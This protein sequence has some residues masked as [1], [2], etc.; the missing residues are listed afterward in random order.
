MGCGEEDASARVR[1]WRRRRRGGGEE[2][3]EGV[4]VLRAE[5]TS[6]RVAISFDA[7]FSS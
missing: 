7:S 5:E 4:G 2:A 3:V 6:G 1:A